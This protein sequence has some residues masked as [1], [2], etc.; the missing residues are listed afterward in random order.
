[1]NAINIDYATQFPRFAIKNSNLNIFFLN[2]RSIRNKLIDMSN[3]LLHN[4]NIIN[5]V[6]LNEHG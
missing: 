3:F 2:I 6:I 5:V 4:K 1:M